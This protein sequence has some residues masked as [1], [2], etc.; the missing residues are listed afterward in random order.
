MAARLKDTDDAKSMS[1]W[2][3][4]EVACARMLSTLGAFEQAEAR[5]AGALAVANRVLPTDHPCVVSIHNMRGVTAKYAGRFDDATAHY[6]QA[7]K[8]LEAGV[9]RAALAGMLHSLGAHW[10]SSKNPWVLSITRSG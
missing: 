2:V 10:R 9:D 4:I 6:E 8:V 3:D 5:L 7:R 1:S